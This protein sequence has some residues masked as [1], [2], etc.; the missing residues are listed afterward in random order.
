MLIRAER[1]HLRPLT[2]ADVGEIYVGW[3]NDPEVVRYLET[4]HAPQT[5]ATVRAFVEAVNA[6]AD[7][8]LFG[9]VLDEGGRHVGN[10]KVGPVHPIH[11]VADVSLLIGARDVWG[12]GY[13]AE[14][15]AAISRHAFAA[16]GVRKLSASLYA[17]NVGSERAFLKAGFVREGLRQAHYDLDGERSDI[18][19]LGCR[20]LPEGEGTI[21]AD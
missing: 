3:L 9:I 19:E 2:L 17:A 12:R 14:A 13:A 20:P 5:L 21:P 11:R 7:E 8:H 10:I 6:R 4:R 16:L 15:I 18:V 1:L